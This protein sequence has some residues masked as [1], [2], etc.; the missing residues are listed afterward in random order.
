MSRN[1]I[2]AELLIG[3]RVIGV[4]G[5]SLGRIEEIIVKL[6]EGTCFVEEFHIGAYALFERLSAWSIGRTILRLAH[7]ARG[8]YSVTPDQL[9]LSDWEEPRLLYPVSEL[10]RLP[11]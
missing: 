3:K 10:K 9:D 2:H 8:G 6:E 4:S 11:G 5:K 7:L 1:E